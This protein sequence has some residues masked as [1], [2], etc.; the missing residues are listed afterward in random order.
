MGCLDVEFLLCRS[1]S[2]G[3]GEENLDDAIFIST[4]F[5]VAYS[6]LPIKDQTARSAVLVSILVR[7][8]REHS[9][10]KVIAYTSLTHS[11]KTNLG[12]FQTQ[13]VSRRQF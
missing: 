3:R 8:N 6:M 4:F 13:I 11:Q 7:S 2:D 10:D 9:A 12:L 5:T 1:R